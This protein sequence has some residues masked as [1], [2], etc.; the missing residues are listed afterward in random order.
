MVDELYWDSRIDASRIN[1]TVEGGT[2]KLAGTVPSYSN[3]YRAE[4]AAWCIS[5]VM[6]VVDDLTV[7]YVSPLSLPADTEIQGW[8]ESLMAWDPTFDEASITISVGG[9]IVTL[10]G[11]VDAL[12]KKSYAENKIS[13]L[14]GVLG[15]ENKLAV[16]PSHKISDEVI[17]QDIV[18]A[19][20]RDALVKAED[21]T[22]EVND[23]GVTLKGK[24]PTWTSKYAAEWDA[25]CTTGV[26]YVE[27]D[28]QLV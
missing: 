6:D 2:V 28:L 13:G 18:S 5:G 9:G 15:V 14:R 1:V 21:V 12:W 23:G 8:A 7:E 4:Q 24:V 16:V 17:S 19:M 26:T 25:S 20:E 3:R 11:T 27:D 10:D 22:V